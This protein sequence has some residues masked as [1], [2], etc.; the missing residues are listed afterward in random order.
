MNLMSMI[1]VFTLTEDL[2]RILRAYLTSTPKLAPDT[3]LGD[4][5]SN[6]SDWDTTDYN[7][8]TEEK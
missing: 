2:Y 1:I 8:N 7:Y 5:D 4:L 6:D 3:E